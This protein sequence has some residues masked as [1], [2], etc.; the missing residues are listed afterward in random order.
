M[1]PAG[2]DETTGGVRGGAFQPK[3]ENSTAS[4]S[5]QVTNIEPISRLGVIVLTTSRPAS[6]CRQQERAKPPAAQEGE[7]NE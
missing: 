2:K 6:E 4:V 7:R 1:P 3:R 5:Y